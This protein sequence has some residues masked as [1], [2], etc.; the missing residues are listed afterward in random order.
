MF[1]CLRYMVVQHHTGIRERYPLLLRIK[2]VVSRSCSRF[3]II[4]LTVD[5]DKNNAFAACCDIPV[6]HDII[7]YFVIFKI[8]PHDAFPNNPFF[9]YILSLKT[10]D[11]GHW[12][13]NNIFIIYLQI[14]FKHSSSAS[15]IRFIFSCR[16]HLI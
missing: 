7:K 8:Y 9:P 13:Y 16:K 5:W 12:I 10:Y 1:T 4:R 6:S 11:S 2:S 14:I 15:S 3:W